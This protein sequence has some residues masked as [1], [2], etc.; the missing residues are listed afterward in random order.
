MKK[1]LFARICRVSGRFLLCVGVVFL[2]GSLLLALSPALFG[3]KDMSKA[4]SNLS[5]SSLFAPSNCSAA[6][7]AGS[8]GLAL[9]MLAVA[10]SVGLILVFSLVLRYYNGSIRSAI[11]KIAKAFRLS[12][13]VTELLCSTFIWT[14]VTLIAIFYTPVFSLFGFAALVLNNLLFIFAWTSYGCPRYTL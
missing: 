7:N 2:T 14:L 9:S 11:A 13:H 12:I 4:Q 6:A 5:I 1:H 10:L 8:N 3:I